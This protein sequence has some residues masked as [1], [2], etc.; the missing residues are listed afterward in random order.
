MEKKKWDLNL[1][2]V[3]PLVI[4]GDVMYVLDTLGKLMCLEKESG[5][6]TWAVQL[7]MK[8][9]K[10]EIAWYGPLLSTNKLIL[11]SSDGLVLSL[12]PFT[13][14]ILSKINFDENF[15]SNPIQ[16]MEKIY[17]ISRQGTLFILG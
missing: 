9:N 8:K 6:L 7:K 5:K 1:S 15:L 12:S 16:V 4:S 11:I 17:L 2:S 10:K 3:N 13:G 14:K